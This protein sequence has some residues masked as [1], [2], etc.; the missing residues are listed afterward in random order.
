MSFLNSALEEFKKHPEELIA[1][2]IIVGGLLVFVLSSFIKDQVGARFKL[3]EMR[4]RLDRE[5]KAFAAKAKL[6]EDEHKR[7]L[8]DRKRKEWRT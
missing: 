5:Q 2:A 6:E 3:T 7:M 4:D 1:P 8:R